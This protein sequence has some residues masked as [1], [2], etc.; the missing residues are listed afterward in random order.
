[1]SELH[2][3]VQDELAA[4]RPNQ[5][6]PFAAIRAR[7]RSHD[8]RRFAGG[9]AALS[10]VV[11]SA[12]VIVPSLASSPDRLP[13][14]A[15]PEP[16]AADFDVPNG[17]AGEYRLGTWVT[18]SVSADRRSVA[19]TV[20]GGGCTSAG[21]HEVDQDRDGVRLLVWVEVLV[22]KDLEHGCGRDFAALAVSV[23][24]PRP[25]GQDEGLLGGCDDPTS[26]ADLSSCRAL[27]APTS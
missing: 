24:L 12:T 10:A 21:R 6:P 11:V 23:D 26:G 19:I 18:Q 8:R 9:A 3:A 7:K 16:P 2:D 13:T 25:L 17:Y 27:R 5:V 1:M 15:A 14:Y 22:P 20:A 4:H